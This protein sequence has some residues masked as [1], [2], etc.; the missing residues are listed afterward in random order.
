VGRSHGNGSLPPAVGKSKGRSRLL[1]I[2]PMVDA[3]AKNFG[4]VL[5]AI[6]VRG[7]GA[8][9]CTKFSIQRY[10]IFEYRIKPSF[11]K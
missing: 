8:N 11:D 1:L 10:A 7:L 3:G 5:R 2:I 4:S 6:A 9:A